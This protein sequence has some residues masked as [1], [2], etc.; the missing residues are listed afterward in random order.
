MVGERSDER[1]RMQSLTLTNQCNNGYNDKCV[2][3]TIEH[4]PNAIRIICFELE[5]QGQYHVLLDFALHYT[6]YE[7]LPAYR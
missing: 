6:E 3:Q 7:F 4:Q 2:A 1:T 5:L